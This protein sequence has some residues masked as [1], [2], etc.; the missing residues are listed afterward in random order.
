[1]F[2]G[3]L[4]ENVRRTLASLSNERVKVKIAEFKEDDMAFMQQFSKEDPTAAQ[5][6]WS[7]IVY[8]RLWLPVYLKDARRCIYLDSDTLVRKPIR[9]LWEWDLG[10]KAYG[11][12]MGSVLEYGYNSGVLL[13]DLRKL[14]DQENW[15][16]L[17]EHMDK[18][19]KLYMFPDQTVLNR[20]YAG[21]ITELPRKFN[22]PPRTDSQYTKECDD[23]VIWH[24][25][26]G[27]TKPALYTESD[28]CKNEWNSYFARAAPV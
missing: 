12:A 28:W 24:F 4:D 18:Y 9:E 26:N 6:T 1:M 14:D 8:A 11:M 27:G 2:Y 23:A 20:Y 22:Y 25:Y 19:A 17:R 13:M 21:Q 5:R 3:H 15:K 10:G 16:A 7:G